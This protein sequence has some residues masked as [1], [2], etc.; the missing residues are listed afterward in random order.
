[1]SRTY[2]RNPKV[3]AK[4][5]AGTVTVSGPYG[6]QTLPFYASGEE[7]ANA[8]NAVFSA[9]PKEDEVTESLSLYRVITKELEN[10]P[11]LGVPPGAAAN[12]ITALHKAGY[13]IVEA[14][15]PAKH[16]LY[17]LYWRSGGESLAAVGTGS[18]GRFWYQ[19]CNWINGPSYDWGSVESFELI[20]GDVIRAEEE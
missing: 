1:M 19:P 16:G 9:V 2:W 18:D 13:A 7:F 15:V 5:S 8:I 20:T 10:L 11:L 4:A 14:T 3:T 6:E 17:R 12:L